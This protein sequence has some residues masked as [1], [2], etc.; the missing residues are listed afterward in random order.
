MK[1]TIVTPAFNSEKYIRETLESVIGQKGEFSIEYIVQDNL[2]TD[3]T[4]SIVR[5]YQQLL[6]AGKMAIHCN[7]VQLHLYTERDAGMYDAIS[8]GFA[9][10]TGNVFAYINSD[11]IYLP[12]AFDA[13]RR[14]LEKYPRISWLKGI[15]SYINERSTI[16]SVGE[17]N[18]YRR[19]WIKAGLYG[20]VLYFIQQDS[21][22]WRAELWRESG[23][24]DVRLAS[25]GDYFLWKAFAELVPLHS[26]HAYVSCFRKV[27]NQKSADINSY[28]S[29]IEQY[30]PPDEYL[31][32]KIRRHS[33][34]MES[35]PEFLRP[36]YYRIA[37]GKYD[38][39]LVRL[40]NGLE[41][42]LVE[43]EYWMLKAML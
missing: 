27:Q 43:G 34:R 3:G 12:G 4:Y 13:V 11:D 16:Y 30:A 14:T 8:K 38:H 18:L 41:P 29:E 22:F 19:D 10:G 21:V 2:S 35:M 25:A 7:E 31:A 37:L 32:K 20:P 24:V 17:C 5:E 9:H 40:E 33:A 15:T 6:A 26:L 23:G 1:F 39:H 28:F 42:S 36:L